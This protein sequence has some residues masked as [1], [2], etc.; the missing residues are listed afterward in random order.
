MSLLPDLTLV[1][2]NPGQAESCSGVDLRRLASDP[3]EAARVA[4]SV[5]LTAL[6]EEVR[7]AVR[8]DM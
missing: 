1:G 5:R 2:P 4:T 7:A 8:R 6:T 3:R